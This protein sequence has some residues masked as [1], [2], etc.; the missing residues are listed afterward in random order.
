MIFG[1]IVSSIL[2]K[3]KKT[4]TAFKVLKEIDSS[5]DWYKKYVLIQVANKQSWK[6]N[7]FPSIIPKLDEIKKA[8]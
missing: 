1:K 7:K 4:K 6:D 2:K 5:V 8:L 3:D